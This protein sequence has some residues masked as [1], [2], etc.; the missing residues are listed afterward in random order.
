MALIFDEIRNKNLSIRRRSVL[1]FGICLV[2][3]L[4]LF[5][6]PS[7]PAQKVTVSNE[8][9]IKSNYAYDIFPDVKGH[10]LFY[11][12]RANEHLLEVY[13]DDLKYKHTREINF[14]AKPHDIITMVKADTVVNVYYV[15][16]ENQRH[17]ISYLSIDS[18]GNPLDTAVHL[19]IQEGMFFPSIRFALSEDRSKLVLFWV[20]GRFFNYM[21]LS[22]EKNSRIVDGGKIECKEFNFKSDFKG[23]TVTN[24]G[25]LYVVGQK[26]RAWNKS[27][28]QSVMVLIVRNNAYEIR[29]L[30]VSE[31]SIPQIRFRYDHVN[32]TFCL[33]GLLSKGDEES[34][35]G[36]FVHRLFPDEDQIQTE[37]T[38]HLFSLEF[39]AE[40]YGKKTT[41]IKKISDV[42]LEDIFIRQDGGILLILEIKK[43]FLRRA[44]SGTM[45]RFGDV[46][47]GRGFIDYY[48]E[49]LIVLSTGPDGREAWKKVLYKKQ[50]SQDDNAIFSS[51]FLFLTPSRMK[52]IYNDEIKTNSTVSEYILDPLGNMERKSVLSTQYQNLKLR[53][54]EAIQISPY[55]LIVPSENIN[56]INI[57]KIDY[58]E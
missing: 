7:L 53:F 55:A 48:N 2:A 9:N 50:F 11:H 52:L 43:E 25:I 10:I 23:L 51:Y 13:D 5:I 17:T 20:E 19:F 24:E 16:K 32:N 15:W 30:G 56:K 45:S 22:N 40:V 8:I 18:E 26:E 1:V 34:I 41:K 27:A 29:F 14:P 46:Y 44:G 33:A 47:S 39:I 35:V 28:D 49:D 58:R 3:V 38:S 21:V 12:D 42:Y 54:Q 37:M 6:I 57:V 36:Y 31:L 4:N